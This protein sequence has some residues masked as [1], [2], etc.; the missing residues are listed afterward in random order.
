MIFQFQ[1][2]GVTFTPED[3]EYFEAKLGTIIKFLG[4]E[5]GDQDSVRAHVKIEKDKH[6][7]GERFHAKGHVTSPHGG[8]FIAEVDAE[9]LLALA[10]KLESTLDR[11]ARKFHQR[12]LQK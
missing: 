6:K 9:N 2:N 11:Q 7:S 12:H 1:T 3:Q 4:S 8:D 10:D 5:A